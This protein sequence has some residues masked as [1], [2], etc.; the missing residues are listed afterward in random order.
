MISPYHRGMMWQ[1]LDLHLG[2]NPVSVPGHEKC[3]VNS[4]RSSHSRHRVTPGLCTESGTTFP[5]G[6]CCRCCIAPCTDPRGC[7]DLCRHRARMTRDEKSY[8]SLSPAG[9]VAG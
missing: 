7:V 9:S 6:V 3:V 2:S 4:V 1:I 8:S 5:T